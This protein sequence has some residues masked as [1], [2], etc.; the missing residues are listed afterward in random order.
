MTCK[1]CGGKSTVIDTAVYED[2]V[3]RKRKCKVLSCEKIFYTI[4]K[5][6]DNEAEAKSMLNEARN[7]T[8]K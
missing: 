1:Y 2:C 8:K 6:F 3:I 5:D 4:E 7:K